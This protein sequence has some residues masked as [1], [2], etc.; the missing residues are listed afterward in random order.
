MAFLT[1]KIPGRSCEF[2]DRKNYTNK[3]Y[4]YYIYKGD[5]EN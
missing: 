2:P 5:F 1:K 4:I 3:S